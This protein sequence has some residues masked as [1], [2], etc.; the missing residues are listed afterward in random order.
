M[1]I[2]MLIVANPDGYAYTHTNVRH[3]RHLVKAAESLL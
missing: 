1:D 2:Y 3:Q